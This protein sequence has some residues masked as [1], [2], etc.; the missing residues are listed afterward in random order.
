M[1]VSSTSI[2]FVTSTMIFFDIILI[3]IFATEFLV[4]GLVVLFE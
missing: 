3:N 2:H 4:E 1:G